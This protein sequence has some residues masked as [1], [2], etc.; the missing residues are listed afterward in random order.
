MGAQQYVM[1]RNQQQ[2]QRLKNC[3]FHIP[4]TTWTLFVVIK[5][6]MPV[7]Q[8]ANPPNVVL[9]MPKILVSQIFPTRVWRIPNVM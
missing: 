5:T 7:E 3:H 2:Q 6:W 1:A 9:W 8:H 4:K